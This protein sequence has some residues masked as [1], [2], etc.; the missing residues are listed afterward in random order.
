M[1]IETLA[2][3][4]DEMIAA[5][6]AEIKKETADTAQ[7]EAKTA[8]EPKDAALQDGETAN[9]DSDAK[10]DTEELALKDNEEDTG[11]DDALSDDEKRRAKAFARQRNETKS[12]KEL[13]EKERAERQADRERLAKLEGRAEALNPSQ[14]KQA[15]VEDVEP[16]KDLYP[17]DHNQ[18]KIAKLEKQ[19]G[20]L[21]TFRQQQE[22][23]MQFQRDM[24]AVKTLEDS[25]K[26]T[27]SDYNEAVDFLVAKERRIKKVF[28]PNL[29][30][31]Q[32]DAQI[33]AEKVGLFKQIAAQGKNPAEV[34]Y[35]IAKEDGWQPKG[36]QPNQHSGAKVDLTK[37]AENQRKAASLIGGTPQAKSGDKVTT[38]AVFGATMAELMNKSGD[39]W[40]KAAKTIKD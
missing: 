3:G 11:E 25:F 20:E 33:A 5:L 2:S 24:G 30:D 14:T 10:D 37:V 34:V 19:L 8:E 28:N 27:N 38:D 6:E 39:F 29:T 36:K 22:Q 15:P 4:A 18:W 31:A 12:L 9:E 7:P 35:Q 32:V 40:E 16:D 17:E 26:A 13:L 23:S 1:S 21:N